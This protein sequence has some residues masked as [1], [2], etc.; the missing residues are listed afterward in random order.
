MIRKTETR[1]AVLR[2]VA[3]VVAVVQGAPSAPVGYS[4]SSAC[5][6]VWQLNFH[7]V[8]VIWV[9]SRTGAV[10]PYHQ[11]RSHLGLMEEKW[12]K[13]WLQEDDARSLGTPCDLRPR[14]SSGRRGEENR[15]EEQLFS[16]PV[17]M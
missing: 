7:A 14:R 12:S 16:P 4:V 8:D 13:E 15:P 9:V 11:R 5:G 6:P 1:R 2:S 10:L 3:A 17:Q